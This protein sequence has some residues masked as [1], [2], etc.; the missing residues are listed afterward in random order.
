MGLLAPLA[1]PQDITMCFQVCAAGWGASRGGHVGYRVRGG[2]GLA[3]GA[4]F[5]N[6]FPGPRESMGPAIQQDQLCL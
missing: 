6:G 5:R 4:A 1:A 2:S 3:S